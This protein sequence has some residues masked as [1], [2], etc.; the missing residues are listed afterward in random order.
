MNDMLFCQSLKFCVYV[1]G[2]QMSGKDIT[3]W[4]HFLKCSSNS[5]YH[6]LSALI[7]SES[8]LDSLLPFECNLILN[9]SSC[10]VLF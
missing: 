10:D 3:S 4:L 7:G 9:F 8:L 2:E 1:C 6:I 5:R